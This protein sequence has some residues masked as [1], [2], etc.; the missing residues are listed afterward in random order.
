MGIPYSLQI[1]INF[2]VEND[3]KTRNDIDNGGGKVN[4]PQTPNF[5]FIGGLPG[6]LLANCVIQFIHCMAVL[7]P[8][9]SSSP[10]PEGAAL[11]IETLNKL[12][13]VPKLSSFQLR[14]DAEMIKAQLSELAKLQFSLLSKGD[15][16]VSMRD[17]TEQIYK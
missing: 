8:T 12:V 15:K 17:D 3:G 16:E 4:G 13:S 5:A 9:L 14:R 6:Q 2:L 11:A 1:F 7:V 10:D